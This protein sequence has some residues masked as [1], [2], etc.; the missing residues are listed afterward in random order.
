MQEFRVTK[1]NPAKRNDKGHYVNSDEWTEYSDVGLSVS[2]EEYEKIERAYINSAIEIIARSGIHSLKVIALQDQKNKC[3]FNENAEVLTASLEPVLRALL[4]GDYWCRLETDQGFIHI[5]WDYYMYIG[6]T[7]VNE[8][9]LCNTKNRG[10]YIETFVSPYH[11][12]S[13]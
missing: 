13:C 11:P 6:V 8:T 12:E 3:E 9:A 1:Y 5:G 2:L 4:R 7:R 10:L